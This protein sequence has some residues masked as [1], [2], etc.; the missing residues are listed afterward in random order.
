MRR[1]LD[2]LFANPIYVWLL[3]L[4]PIVYLYSENLG[5]V[6]DH[7]VVT[8]TGGVLGIVTLAFFCVNLLL[9]NRFRAAS[10][11]G[12]A[13]VFFSLSGHV[14]GLFLAP[15][16]VHVDI[17]I[18]LWTQFVLA[19]AAIT[20]SVAYRKPSIHL[21]RR[22][23]KITNLVVVAMLIV[24]ASAIARDLASTDVLIFQSPEDK[25]TLA[26]D[27][28][29]AK[30]YDSPSYPDIYYIIPDGYPSNRWLQESM[31]YDNSAFSRALES[32]GFVVLDHAQS[33]YGATLH[34][35][36]ATLNLRYYSS[37]D[38]SMKDL[39]FLRMQI[40]E[41]EVAR[42]LREYGY[43]YVQLLSGYLLPS[44]LADINRDF[45][46][47]GTIDI[48]INRSD[49]LATVSG[50]LEVTENNIVSLDSTYK[51][52][53]MR[54]YVD[55][56]LL[57]VLPSL[58][59]ADIFAEPNRPYSLV[60]PERFLNTVDEVT[61]ITL[62]P[63]ATVALIHLMK[64]HGPTVFNAQGEI[65]AGTWFPSHEQYFSEF[66]FVNATFIQ[67]IDA[68]LKNSASPPVIVFQ[69]D[70]G[71]TYGYTWSNDDRL[72]HFDAFAAYHLPDSFDVRFP[73]P[74][75]LVNTFPIILN[76]VLGTEF[77]VLENRLFDLPQGYDAP[78]EQMDVTDEFL[79]R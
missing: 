31:N 45:A 49:L 76:E 60:A 39:D 50:G 55:T 21:L 25:D 66:V 71:S 52:S 3:G 19:A 24:P 28:A 51:Q 58:L 27:Q 43:S 62:M 69:A 79:R 6:I 23:T 30:I 14:Y 78:F 35:L 47:S 75:T 9:R 56:T 2:K 11:V 73:E 22:I 17:E 32:R 40:A 29:S 15:T 72:T 44:P 33:N 42:Q 4:Y 26:T 74:F 67:M 5:L 12:I 20:I 59:Q 1:R 53:F 54:L 63:E 13:V 57:R 64:P 8:V 61:S 34:S 10:L 37:N 36:A 48:T 7:E 38:S 16:V 65:V 18:T 41:N 70:H 68:I 77:A 46:P